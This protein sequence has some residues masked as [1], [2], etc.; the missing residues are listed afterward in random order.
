MIAQNL[1]ARSGF[2]RLFF[3]DILCAMIEEEQEAALLELLAEHEVHNMTE[4]YALYDT[5]SAAEWDRHT[6]GLKNIETL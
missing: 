1:A 5:C 4:V 6:E 3:S 2:S